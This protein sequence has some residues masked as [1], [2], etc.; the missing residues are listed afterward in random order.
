M[1]RVGH[2]RVNHLW[3]GGSLLAWL[4][5]PLSLLFGLIVA[6]RRFLYERRWLSVS[7]VGAPVIVVGNIAVGGTGKT[8]VS[9]WLATRLAADGYHPAVVS[10]GYGGDVGTEPL[11]VSLDSDPLRVGDEALLLSRQCNCPVVVHPDRAAAARKA[12]ELGADVIVSD[13]GLQHYRMARDF[14]I[15]VIDGRR[16]FGNGFLLPAG[17]LREPQSRLGRA[18]AVVVQ[19]PSD[20]VSLPPGIAP[21]RFCLSISGVRNLDSGVT[22]SIDEFRGK[23]VHAVAGIGHP[24]RFFTMLE[25]HGIDVIRH[26]LADHAVISAGDIR[27]DDYLP[28]LMTEKDAVKCSGYD[29]THCSSVQVD[30]TFDADGGDALMASICGCLRRNT[31]DRKG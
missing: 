20:G 17:P 24:E 6:L 12:V 19:D 18:D 5:L 3:Y 1:S 25:K 14:E 29:L 28:V 22:T 15:V 31:D 2:N 26:P 4:L 27:F 10:R 11:A 7:D 23:T 16:G 8:P 30:V 21:L 9:G 13:D